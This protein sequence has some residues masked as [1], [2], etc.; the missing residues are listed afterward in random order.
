M[1]GIEALQ[2]NPE[3]DIVISDYYMPG[4]DGGQLY[5]WLKENRPDIPFL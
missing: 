2:E 5:Q 3:I 4:G 1:D